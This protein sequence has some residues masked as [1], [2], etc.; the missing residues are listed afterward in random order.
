MSDKTSG[1]G[2]N[3]KDKIRRREADPLTHP[4]NFMAAFLLIYLIILSPLILR[5]LN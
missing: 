2:T 5:E 3:T 4:S 1:L